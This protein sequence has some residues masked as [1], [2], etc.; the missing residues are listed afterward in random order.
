MKKLESLGNLNNLNLGGN[1]LIPNMSA[2][3]SILKHESSILETE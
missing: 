1:I 3:N 2:G